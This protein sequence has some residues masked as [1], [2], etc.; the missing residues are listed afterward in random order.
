[1]RL[2]ASLLALSL[3]TAMPTA[4]PAAPAGS[5]PPPCAGGTVFEEI[6]RAHV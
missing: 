4:A 1:M 3:L 5:A 6:G 2:R